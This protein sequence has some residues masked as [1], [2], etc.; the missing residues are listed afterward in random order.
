MGK[1]NE[2]KE[3]EE[4]TAKVHVSA[5]GLFSDFILALAFPLCTSSP[6]PQG[7]RATV[8]N[9]ETSLLLRRL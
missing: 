3:K 8:A 1:V 4:R 5:E 2:Q 9:T 6:S 7:M